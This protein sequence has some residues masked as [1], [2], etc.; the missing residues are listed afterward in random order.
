MS[1]I[2]KSTF[3]ICT[4]DSHYV[5]S[6][7]ILCLLNNNVS[8]E[9]KQGGLLS[10]IL[11]AIIINREIVKAVRRDWCRMPHGQPLY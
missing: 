1:I 11:F 9:V 7:E 4:L 2:F 3:I 8:K 10:P 5:R 6:R